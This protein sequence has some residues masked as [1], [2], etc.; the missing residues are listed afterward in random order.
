MSTPGKVLVV[1]ILLTFVGWI[2]LSSAVTQLNKDWQHAINKLDQD[3]AGKPEER[4][5]GTGG[6][7]GQ[8][9]ALDAK[10]K[11]L[12]NKIALMQ[13]QTAH[14]VAVARTEISDDREGVETVTK[15]RLSRPRQL[16]GRQ[17]ASDREAGVSEAHEVRKK[18]QADANKAIA[19][20][21]ALVETLKTEVGE[22]FATLDRLRSEFRQT[23]ADNQRRLDQVRKRQG[24]VRGEAATS[25]R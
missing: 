19:D 8:V 22:Q 21:T 16:D 20:E 3:I 15:E 4:A 2:V 10:I 17:R 5:L 13:D 25:E 9:A 12:T 6:L 7:V 23:L 14:D 1:L 24:R 11:D 18:E